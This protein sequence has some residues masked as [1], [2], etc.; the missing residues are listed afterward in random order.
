MCFSIYYL[1]PT[2]NL[3]YCVILSLWALTAKYK[4]INMCFSYVMFPNKN[5]TIL[6]TV[7][8]DTEVHRRFE[9]Y[10][11]SSR[12]LEKIQNI[13][14]LS[15]DLTS[16]KRQVTTHIFICIDSRHFLLN[17]TKIYRFKRREAPTA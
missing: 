8:N 4:T 3:T 7:L 1:K 11:Q 6:L 5:F 14:K 2:K 10:S 17:F 13:L 9:T 12:R 15:D 16:M